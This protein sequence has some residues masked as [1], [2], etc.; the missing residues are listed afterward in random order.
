MKLKLSCVSVHSGWTASGDERTLEVNM[1]GGSLD[2]A[3]LQLRV[4][5]STPEQRAAFVIGN[6]YEIDIPQMPD[7]QDEP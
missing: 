5:R 4:Y 3:T 1:Q 7:K 2:G 6:E